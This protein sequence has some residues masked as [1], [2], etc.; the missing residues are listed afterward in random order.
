[1]VLPL[2]RIWCLAITWTRILWHSLRHAG[3]QQEEAL[4]TE[5]IDTYRGVKA[6][7]VPD[8]VGRCCA[9]T[10]KQMMHAAMPCC[11][12]QCVLRILLLRSWRQA[13]SFPVSDKGCGHAHRALG[14]RGNART[15]Q[16]R[17][18]AA[19]GDF[20]AA[21]ELCPWAVDPVLNR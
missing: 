18:N 12:L 2:S 11:A 15:R 17:L 13:G 10:D 14:N 21:I 9:C 5:L 16:G 7:W 3:L 1:M 20:N 8:I 19:L 4:W 6:D